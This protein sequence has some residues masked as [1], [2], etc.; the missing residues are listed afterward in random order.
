M[1]YFN[2]VQECYMTVNKRK[3]NSVLNKNQC[4]NNK[5][6]TKYLSLDITENKNNNYDIKT[7]VNNNRKI[8]FSKSYSNFGKFNLNFDDKP[9]IENNGNFI[10]NAKLTFV[11]KINRHK[12]NLEKFININKNDEIKVQ[13][14][15]KKE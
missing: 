14:K 11:P 12:R 7:F 9:N 1:S 5:I 3:T 15:E 4:K 8:N 2:D 10:K 13:T 6:L